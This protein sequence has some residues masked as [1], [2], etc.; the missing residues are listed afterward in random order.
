M[1]YVTVTLMT[2][3]EPAPNCRRIKVKNYRI[4]AESYSCNNRIAGLLSGRPDILKVFGRS[5]EDCWGTLKMRDRKMRDQYARVENAGLENAGNDIVW[6]TVYSLCCP[7]CRTGI[8]MVLR[9]Y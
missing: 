7:I 5:S 1:Y 8:S 4:E 2:F 6:N 9:L 3:V